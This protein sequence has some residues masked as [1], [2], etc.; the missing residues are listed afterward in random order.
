[1]K[2]VGG[3]DLGAICHSSKTIETKRER[4]RYKKCAESR[5]L[6]RRLKLAEY[7]Q[8]G[9]LRLDEQDVN[10]RTEL[11]AVFF[12]LRICSFLRFSFVQTAG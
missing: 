4:A 6:H 8:F 2:I 10:R 12:I 7:E 9:T 3:N 11:V 1:M 5:L